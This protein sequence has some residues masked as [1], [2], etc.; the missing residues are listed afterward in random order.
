MTT[1][2]PPN[3]MYQN[4]IE[5]IELGVEDFKLSNQDPRRLASAVRNLTAGVLLL[6][7]EKLRRLSPPGSNDVLIMERIEFA[8]GPAGGISSIGSGKKTV[9]VDGIKKRYKQLGLRLDEA[10]LQRLVDIRNDVEHRHSTKP[11]AEVQAAI[12]ASFWLVTDTLKH[13]LGQDPAQE[14]DADVWGTMV[15][16]A[17]TFQKLADECA[18]SRS[19]VGAFA[20]P[21][22]E[23]ILPAIEC[24]DCNSSLM[25]CLGDDYL[26]LT[27]RCLVCGEESPLH[28]VVVEAV[29]AVFAAHDYARVKDG[30]EP[31]IVNCPDCAERAFHLEEDTCLACGASRQYQECTRCSATLSVE[32]QDDGGLCSY[33]A[34]IWHKYMDD[35]NDD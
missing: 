15:T 32:E 4:A 7:K 14:L 17:E 19:A 13:H 2:A 3:P 16:E 25:K 23:E 22:A 35:D 9:D 33:C 10:R 12:A 31:A 18:T 34:H 6:L 1:S 24:P 21:A 5:A 27:F 11:T 26:D 8:N 29:A 30:D 28:S 20:C